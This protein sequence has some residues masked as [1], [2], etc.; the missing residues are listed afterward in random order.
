MEILARK[1]ITF[2]LRYLNINELN[3]EIMLHII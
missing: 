1:K 3:E 2:K